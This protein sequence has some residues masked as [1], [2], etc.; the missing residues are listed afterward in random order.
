MT[1]KVRSKAEIDKKGDKRNARKRFLRGKRKRRNFGIKAARHSGN[2]TR[3]QTTWRGAI[4]ARGGGCFKQG[5]SGRRDGSGG[6]PP[7]GRRKRKQG[8]GGA[9]CRSRLKGET[10]ISDFSFRKQKGT[11]GREI[12]L[13]S[14]SGQG[15]LCPTLWEKRRES[16]CS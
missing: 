4:S 2:R 7:S 12:L 11:P 13:Q 8:G 6:G 15:N 1:L 10:R 5:G 9:V 16:V 3:K 14:T